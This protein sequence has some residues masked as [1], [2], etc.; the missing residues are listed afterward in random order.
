MNILKFLCMLNFF[1]CFVLTK[2]I[3]NTIYLSAIIIEMYLIYMSMLS[4][5]SMHLQCEVFAKF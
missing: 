5:Y 2:A 1:L 4:I 3:S